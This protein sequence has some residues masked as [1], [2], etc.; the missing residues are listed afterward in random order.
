MDRGERWAQTCREIAR[1]RIARHATAVATAAESSSKNMVEAAGV[2]PFE[3]DNN[4]E[5]LPSLSNDYVPSGS[6]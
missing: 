6:A 1:L 2:E 4:S 3:I 5:H